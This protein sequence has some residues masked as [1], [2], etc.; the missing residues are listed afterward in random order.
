MDENAPAAAGPGEGAAE[1]RRLHRA[2]EGR[3]VLGVCAG[4]GRATGIDPVLFRVGLGLL[5]LASGVGVM[6]YAAGWL[7]MGDPQGRPSY[8]EQWTS[9][10]FEPETVLALMG[11]VF[12]LGVVVNLGAGGV[13]RPTI[14]VATVFV[15]VLL[16]AHARGADLRTLMRTLPERV[17]RSRVTPEEANRPSAP[18]PVPGPADEPFAP[19]GPYAGRAA[20]GAYRWSRHHAA[21]AAAPPA[22][23]PPSPGA[24]VPP[25]A[26]PARGAS[27]AG[28]PYSWPPSA[29]A[30]GAPHA[31]GAPVPPGPARAGTGA[32]PPR[33]GAVPYGEAMPYGGAGAA[34]PPA[35][36]GKAG[37]E[38]RPRTFLALLTLLAAVA[39]GAAV[40]GHLPGRQDIASPVL[41]GAVLM[42]VGAGLVV[43]AWYGRATSLV[44][45]GTVMSLVL[46]G[47]SA[48]SGTPKR[49]GD[50]RWEP[51][52]V[53]E[54]R[55]EHNLAV[56][57]GRLD[58]TLLTLAPGS[59]TRV[60]A[61]V[62]LGEME[63]IVPANARV[64]VTATSML[65]DV[66]IDG[67]MRGGAN[68]RHERVIEAEPDAGPNPPVIE[69]RVRAS[70]G[71]VEVRR[72]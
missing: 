27:A 32:P 70:L 29:A 52:G 57:S 11:A 33:G 41:G 36:R 10:R 71:D 28:A 50:Q 1:P 35:K 55:Q 69:L 43:S 65:G 6:L 47:G 72:G 63:V 58:L 61:A 3:M 62:G 7:L 30:G 19:H 17:S 15:I 21:A 66:R 56:G 38:R 2:A 45:V 5:V 13:G 49:F 46:I 18:P 51:A 40:A 31:G 44:A 67:R 53:P 20:D 9:R 64:E 54:A 26:P 4:L 22:G 16:A 8:L 34:A 24:S 39:V 59:R 42:T 25:G 60:E 48:V 23:A 68:V 14:V 12:A 37:K